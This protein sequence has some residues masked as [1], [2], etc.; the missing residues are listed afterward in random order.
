MAAKDEQLKVKDEEVK[1]TLQR[2]QW[3][4]ERLN[5]STRALYCPTSETIQ[6][7]GQYAIEGFSEMFNEAELCASEHIVKAH[8]PAKPAREKDSDEAN[9]GINGI[10]PKDTPVE[11]VEYRLTEDERICKDCGTLMEE[12]QPE[13]RETLVIIPQRVK[14]RR[15]VFYIYKCPNCEKETG[16][17]KFKKTPRTPAFLEK[18]YA[19]P[20]AVAYLMCQKYIMHSPL[21]RLENDFTSRQIK[22]SR[23]TMSNWLIAASTT[24]LK[25][26]YDGL[27]RLLCQEKV[28]HADETTL[29]VL[30]E[31]GKSATSKSYMWM[32]RTG[33]YAEQQIVLYEYQPNRKAENAQNFLKEFSGWLHADGYQGYHKL[34][35]SIGVVGCWAHA[36]RK[37]VEA[38]ETLSP[39]AR[40]G[41]KVA[42]GFAMIEKLFILEAAFEDLTPEERYIKRLEQEKPVLDALLSWAKVT[43]KGLAPKTSH[44][45]AIHY[46]LEQWEYLIRYLEDGRLVMTNNLAERSIKSFVMGR[47][48]WL[49]SKTPKGANASSVIFSMVETAKANNLDP[50]RYL[51]WIFETAP[52]LSETDPDWA[53]KLIPAYAPESCK[54]TST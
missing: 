2:L 12:F 14:I 18:S 19:S 33:K 29:Q 42:E 5:R 10:V 47:K 22:L 1:S 15:E 8:K 50:Y 32:Y 21:Y 37:F 6:A 41:S 49:F 51:T 7:I 9:T 25:P 38:L 16:D 36:R 39:D 43:G 20:E 3:L 52:S 48:N 45:K 28:L 23:Q 27:H 54:A 46:L 34:P 31:E 35:S 30:D 53:S 40:K 11:V 13:Y 44:S 24:W 4:I 26:V 17:S